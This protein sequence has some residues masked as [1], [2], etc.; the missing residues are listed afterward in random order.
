MFTELVAHAAGEFIFC[1]RDG[2]AALPKLLWDFLL[3]KVKDFLYPFAL[4][5]GGAY[6]V[7]AKHTSNIC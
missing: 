5:K 4:W 7:V 1:V 3:S 2:N 6:C